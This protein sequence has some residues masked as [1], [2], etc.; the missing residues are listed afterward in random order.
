M[1]TATT[2]RSTE[3][4]AKENR[5]YVRTLLRQREPEFSAVLELAVQLE[6]ILAEARRA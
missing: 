4:R 5:R 2:G 6:L 1:A 3:K